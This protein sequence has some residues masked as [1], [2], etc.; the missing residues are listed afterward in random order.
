MRSALAALLLLSPALATA[1]IAAEEEVEEDDEPEWTTTLL[2][3]YDTS[4]FRTNAYHAGIELAWGT[5]DFWLQLEL[6]T[7]SSFKQSW[8]LRSDSFATL[9]IGQTLYE[10]E[11]FTLVTTLR[12]DAHSQL[13][14]QGGDVTPEVEAQLQLAEDW[15]LH[16]SLGAVLATAPE[17]DV[18]RGFLSGNIWLGYSCGWLEEDELSLNIW[19]AG[20][21]IPSDDKVLFIELEYTFAA[22]EKLE[23]SLG[24]GT[25]PISPW[26]HLG[27]YGTA[28][29]R[30][31]F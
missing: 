12:L 5:T 29:L 9:E 15:E 30:W 20:N 28:G 23:V 26:D 27:L 2:V 7:Y 19:A 10:E 31:S 14:T 21:E 6:D 25:D 8:D 22:T 16:V 18:K 24:L 4:R 3:D 1:G 13:S 17:E 11:A